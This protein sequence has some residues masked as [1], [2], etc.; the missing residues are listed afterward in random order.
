[1]M[2]AGITNMVTAR[3]E[4]RCWGSVSPEGIQLRH[5]QVLGCEEDPQAP[6]GG[7]ARLPHQT[8]A[9]SFHRLLGTAQWGFRFTSPEGGP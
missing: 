5:E 4:V 7:A 3:S 1:M 6:E 9:V 8:E 2:E